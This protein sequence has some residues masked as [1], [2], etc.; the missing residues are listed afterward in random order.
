MFGV[1]VF[2]SMLLSI[3]RSVGI[4][5]V[6]PREM[7]NARAFEFGMSKVLT[8]ALFLICFNDGYSVGEGVDQQ[9]EITLKLINMQK[10]MRAIAA[11]MLTV[12]V[13]CAAGCT[14]DNMSKPTTEGIYLG[15]IGFNEALY[16]KEIGLLNTSTQSSFTSFIDGLEMKRGTGL[17]WADNTAIKGLKTFGEPPKL[18]KVA[19]VTFSDGLDNVSLGDNETNPENYSTKVAYLNALSDKIRHDEVYGESIDAYTIGLMG[20]DVTDVNE[21]HSNLRKLA[22]NDSNAFEVSDMNEALQ[23]FTEIAESLHTVTAT[24]SLSL[25]IP[26]GYDDGTIVR[27]TFD[28]ISS[29]EAAQSTSYIECT[30][31]REENGRRLENITCGGWQIKVSS[32]SSVEKV[33][34]YYKVVFEDLT[35]ENGDLVSD[36][37]KTYLQL[38]Y[39]TATGTWQIDSEFEPDTHSDIIPEQESAII[40]LVL[41]CT[42][43]LGDDFSTMKTA[44][45]RFV[46]TLVSSNG[47]GSNNGGGNNGG[48][49]SGGST[50]PTVTTLEVTEISSNRAVSG[51]NVTNNGGSAISQVGVCWSTNHNPTTSDNHA[52]STEWNDTI[53]SVFFSMSGLSANTTYYVRAYA[54]NAVGTCYGQERSFTTSVYVPNY[55]PAPTGLS[56][57]VSGS[58]I[59]VTWNSVPEAN[60]YKIYKRMASWDGSYYYG[61]LDDISGGNT[62]TYYDTNPYS[63]NYY[64]V[65]AVYSDPT[66]DIYV[67]SGLSDYTYCNYGGGGK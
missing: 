49:N 61:K 29:T 59:N 63:D 37:D 54:T 6:Y 41:D 57:Y 53:G 34:K 28:N 36:G 12:A 1:H 45:K 33:G 14:K 40:M 50:I 52:W 26:Q 67:E 47:G 58:R 5:I 8:P 38:F 22:S 31:K 30:Y 56:S 64:K 2:V 55:L 62:T 25:L 44:A 7:G 17:Y 3:I 43:S 15:V 4:G 19:L 35:K 9:K 11:I 46:E 27:F 39:K 48:G 10:F 24:A 13:V 16:E 51:G 18:A 60:A 42:T 65:R 21:F 66:H 23:K 32:V 20:N